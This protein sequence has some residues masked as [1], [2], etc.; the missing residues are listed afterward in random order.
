[1]AT[2]FFI[3]LIAWI[4][5]RADN[6][7]NAFVYIKDMFTTSLFTTPEIL[8]FTILGLVAFFTFIEWLGRSG[9]YAIEKVDFMKRPVRWCFYFLLVVLIF[10]FTGEQQEFIYF[11]F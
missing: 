1:M 7:T 2:T 4:F 3:T 9:E 8:P 10:S 11:Q 5:F 6:V